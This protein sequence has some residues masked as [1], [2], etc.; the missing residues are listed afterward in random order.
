LTVTLLSAKAALELARAAAKMNILVI[1]R[2]VFPPYAMNITNS[3]RHL[4][5]NCRLVL[6]KFGK[7]FLTRDWARWADQSG[8]T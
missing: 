5:S 7:V 6:V 1:G 4:S 8:S 3:H 2:I